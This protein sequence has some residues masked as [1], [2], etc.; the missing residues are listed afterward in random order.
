ML[1]GSIAKT[2]I[3]VPLGIVCCINKFSRQ[4]LPFKAF[5]QICMTFCQ[6]IGVFLTN[7]TRNHIKHGFRFSG[8]ILETLD[9]T[10]ACIVFDTQGILRTVIGF[11]LVVKLLTNIFVKCFVRYENLTSFQYRKFL[12]KQNSQECWSNQMKFSILL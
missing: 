7:L 9:K 8:S 2:F 5:F 10:T 6:S 3:V 11:G 1:L 4:Y 12:T